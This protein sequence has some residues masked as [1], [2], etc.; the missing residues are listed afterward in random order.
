MKRIIW[1]IQATA[2]Y[3]FTGAMAAIPRRF[4][5]TIGRLTGKL[6]YRLLARRRKIAIDN[7]CQALP[8]M[9]RHPAWTGA[10][11][12]AE[13]IAQLLRR[14]LMLPELVGHI[15]GHLVILDSNRVRFRPALQPS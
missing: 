10:F 9:K 15:P 5:H 14:F 12:T 3:L 2:F 11:N 13:E 8:F 4:T 6:M 1:V 7:I